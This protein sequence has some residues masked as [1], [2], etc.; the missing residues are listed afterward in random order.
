M[1]AH[2]ES[3]DKNA[4]WSMKF[5]KGTFIWYNTYYHSRQAIKLILLI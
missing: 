3:C 2:W 4:L 1:P 5:E